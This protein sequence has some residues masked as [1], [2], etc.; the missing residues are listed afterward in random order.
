MSTKGFRAAAGEG[1]PNHMSVEEFRVNA[2][3]V[4]DWLCDYYE[5]IESFP[6]LS[7]VEPGFVR[8]SLPLSAPIAPEDFSIIMKDLEEVLLP[9]ITH[10]QSPNFFGYFPANA[11][12]PSILGEMISAGLGVQGMLWLTSPSCTELETLVLDW[13]ID[14]LALP[15]SYKSTG[16]GGGVIQDSASSA[17]LCALLAAREAIQKNSA[18][19]TGTDPRLV[20]YCSEE[21][22]SSVEK[23]FSIAGL[24]RHR[25]RRV[26]TDSEGALSLEYLEAQMASDIEGGLLPFFICAT[27]G[28]TSTLSSDRV[29]ELGSLASTNKCWLHVDA[30]MAG[31]ASICPEFRYLNRGLELTDSYCFNPHKWML[32]NFDCNCF[33]VNDRRPLN[34]AMSVLPEY[35]KNEKSD[36]SEVIDFRDWQIPL[37][38][39][40][41]SLKLWFVIRSYGVEGIRQFVRSHA[42]LAKDFAQWVSAD[43]DFELVTYT[44]L[45]LVCFRVMGD[46]RKNRVL[47]DTLNKTGRIFLS[48]TVVE[49]RFVL[50]LC[51]GQVRV[52]EK[53]VI[54]AWETIK[55][56]AAGL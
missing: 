54:R 50:R 20:G 12:P 42:K 40:F 30:A 4:V 19:E 1:G 8:S 46:D 17:V 18:C 48:H 15:Q 47:L 16:K 32:T 3:R 41:R 14:M 37:G 11:S 45:N 9:G 55:T 52:D 44:G 38:R 43:R 53:T 36:K 51:V 21:A 27:V 5:N 33:Y 35:L 39:R 31:T 28:T 29:Q 10:W 22:H 2:Y 24:G 26:R 56:V 23:A 34:A 7:E 25:L 6:V 13:I 49:G